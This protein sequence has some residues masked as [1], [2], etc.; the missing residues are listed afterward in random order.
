MINADERRKALERPKIIIDGVSYEGKLLSWDAWTPHLLK[1][2]GWF[3]GD[4]RDEDAKADI[5]AFLEA[6]GLPAEKILAL[7]PAVLEE[8]ITDFFLCHRRYIKAPAG[9]SP[10]PSS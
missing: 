8:A 4:V 5:K 7:E 9:E 1:L 3:K 2:D 10:N 6:I